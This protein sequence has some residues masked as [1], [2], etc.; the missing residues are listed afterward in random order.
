MTPFHTQD[1]AGLYDRVT[2]TLREHLVTELG[3]GALAP[4]DLAWFEDLIVQFDIEFHHW[5]SYGPSPIRTYLTLFE[6]PR[7]SRY[8]RLAAHAYLHIAYDLPRVI[9][10]T[11]LRAPGSRDSKRRAFLRPGPVFLKAFLMH[12]RAGGFGG[13]G[14]I[15]GRF[16]PVQMLA[17]WVIALRTVAWVH[18]EILADRGGPAGLEATM[19]TE[20]V[21]AAEEAIAYPWVLGVVELDNSRLFQVMPASVTTG[22][23]SGAVSGLVSAILALLA[24]LWFRQ[25]RREVDTVTAQ[26]DVLG[27]LVYRAMVRSLDP[28]WVAVELKR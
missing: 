27:A 28:E 11:L 2:K 23:L 1:F 7:V 17:Y 19:A 22:L 5:N 4:P 16:K 9:S 3:V 6:D 20:L 13:P 26:I 21:N 12:A 24:V 8:L 10:T 14:R 18:A 15:I 25:R